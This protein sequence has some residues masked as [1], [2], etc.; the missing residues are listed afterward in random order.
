MSSRFIYILSQNLLFKY[1]IVCIS[2][3]LFIYFSIDGYLGCFH[4]LAL[5]KN[6]AMNMSVQISLRD[7]VLNSFGYI[8]R[9][10]ISESYDNFIFN[11]F[12]NCHSVFH[13]S[14]TILYSHQQS[15]TRILLSPHP[16]Q[17]SPYDSF[18][19]SHHPNKY[20]MVSHCSFELRFP[21]YSCC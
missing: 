2:H 16:N 13:S 6:A 9:S 19:I 4:L 8:S 15:H 17:L 18:F 14:C 10:R 21:N 11:I 1:S 20:E 12:R 7:H 3:T 5:V